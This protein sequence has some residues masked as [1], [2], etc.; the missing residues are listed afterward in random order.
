MAG[1]GADAEEL[2]DELG[3]SARLGAKSLLVPT[4]LTCPN[5]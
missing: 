2:C 1:N 3:E 5:L 4:E